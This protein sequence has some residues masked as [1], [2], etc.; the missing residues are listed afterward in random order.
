[1]FPKFG[2]TDYSTEVTRLLATK[3]MSF[4]MVHGAAISTRSSARQPSGNCSNAPYSSCP[5]A[6]PPSNASERTCRPHISL[7]GDHWFLHPAPEDAKRLANFTENFRKRAGVYPIYPCFHGAGRV[8]NEGGVRQGLGDEERRLADRRG[9]RSRIQRPSVSSLTSPVKIREDGQ[10]LASMLVGTTTMDPK[11]PFPILSDMVVFP[12]EMVKTPVGKTSFDWLKTLE[13]EIPFAGPAADRV[14]RLTAIMSW[15]G[16]NGMLLGLAMLDGLV[17]CR[18]FSWSRW[19]QSGLR[20]MRVLNF[21]HG[22]SLCDRRLRG[23]VPEPLSDGSGHAAVISL[24]L[25]VVSS[26]IVGAI[27][28]PPIE[29]LLRSMQGR[30]K[31]SSSW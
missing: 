17:V 2:A 20:W 31:S 21:V 5:S 15:F 12:G 30:R 23:S 29:R 4:S 19:D 13:P 28:G 6:N 3:P 26:A 14:Q 10:G 1:M 11:Y 9:T 27:L 25:L 18:P 8:R 22:S 24:P 16:D 7:R